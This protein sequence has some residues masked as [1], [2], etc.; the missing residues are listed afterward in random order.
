MSQILMKKLG[1]TGLRMIVKYRRLKIALMLACT[2][3][4]WFVLAQLYNF[5]PV[6]LIYF[7][8]VL[9]GFFIGAYLREVHE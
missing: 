2:G 4:P 9:A 5:K 6:H 1:A 8:G 3:L 7:F